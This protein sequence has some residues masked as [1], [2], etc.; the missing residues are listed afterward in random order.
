[1]SLEATL[2][3]IVHCQRVLNEVA[4]LSE[5]LHLKLYEEP[6]GAEVL[7]RLSSE[8]LMKQQRIIT[9]ATRAILAHGYN[10]GI[11]D[12][13]LEA[14]EQ[15]A[16][17]V[18]THLQDL[19]TIWRPSYAALERIGALEPLNDA[20]RT[21]IS[22]L[23]RLESLLMDLGSHPQ[24]SGNMNLKLQLH[25][26]D[27]PA[28]TKAHSTDSGVDLTCMAVE[29]KRERVYM[30]DLGVSVEPPP[31]Y[32]TE[33]FPRSSIIKTDFVQAN[34]VGIID[35]DYRGRIYLPLRYLGQGDGMD[36]ARELIGQRVAQLILKRIEPFDLKI[37]DQLNDTPRGQGGFGSTGA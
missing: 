4:V 21:S 13:L 23:D 3:E 11:A 36:K 1:M 35:Q 26:P 29:E 2:N 19:S 20:V 7:S 28:P 18:K 5:A 10:W 33:L 14:L 25:Y 32:Y 22:L 31:G 34:S 8:G 17:K 37:V 6:F 9:T 16:Q 12:E 24:K 30:L 15:S 27:M